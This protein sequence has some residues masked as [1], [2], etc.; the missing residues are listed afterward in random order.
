M[1]LTLLVHV[2]G[3]SLA[4]G[5]GAVALAVRKGGRVHRA[6][7]GVFVAAMFAM[8]GATTLL[9]LTL[10]VGRTCRAACSPSISSGRVG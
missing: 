8:G 2:V 5:C 1:N 6:S 4:I 10:P 7:G 3:G 9:A